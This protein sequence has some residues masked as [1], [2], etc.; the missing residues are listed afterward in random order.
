MN[1]YHQNDEIEV[2]NPER[3]LSDYQYKEYMEMKENRAKEVQKRKEKYEEEADVLGINP[4]LYQ[5]IM[6]ER[7]LRNDN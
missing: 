4:E 7:S 5:L 6:N 3:D 1:T 2:F